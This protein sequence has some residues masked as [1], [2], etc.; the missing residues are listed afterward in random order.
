[1]KFWLPDISLSLLLIDED[2]A[3]TY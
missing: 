1:M 3:F 2:Y